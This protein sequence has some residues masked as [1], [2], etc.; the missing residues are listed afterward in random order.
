MIG[1]FFNMNGKKQLKVIWEELIKDYENC[2]LTI[3]AW[4][5]ANQVK[6]HQ[7][8]YWRKILILNKQNHYQPL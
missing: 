7:F 1:G 3:K 2:G 8:F 5:E 4:C 6:E